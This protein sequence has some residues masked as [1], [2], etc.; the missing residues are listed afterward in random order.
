M[1][2]RSFFCS[3]VGALGAV[4]AQLFGGWTDALTVLLILMAIDYASGLAVA[5]I[6]HKSPKS[7][8]GALESHAGL[9]G[10]MRKFFVICIVVTA[11]LIDRL[12]GTNYL[13][14]ACA[15]AFC[16]NEV[17]SLVENIG[18]MGV[19]MPKAL[20][21]AIDVLRQKSGEDGDEACPTLPADTGNAPPAGT[22]GTE[23]F[24]HQASPDTPLEEGGKTACGV[25]IDGTEAAAAKAA[26]TENE[27]AAILQH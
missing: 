5:G 20:I 12:L 15:I 3:A 23:D 17:I 13:R 26:E 8:T 24:P 10:L 19:P 4:V 7:K 22:A 11:L 21:R 14:D 6:F 25:E 2:Y 9:K 18:L 27:N 16:L 1:V